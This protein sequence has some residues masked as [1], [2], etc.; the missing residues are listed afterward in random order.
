MSPVV[1]AA[2][3]TIGI[4]IAANDYAVVDVLFGAV[5]AITDGQ[6]KHSCIMPVH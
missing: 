4:A 2:S 1:I 6:G 5:V 3:D